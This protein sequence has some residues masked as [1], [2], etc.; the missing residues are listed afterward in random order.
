MADNKSKEIDIKNHILKRDI[1]CE[2]NFHDFREFL[3][4]LR[5]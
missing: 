4:N 1:A 2:T 3:Q 5:N